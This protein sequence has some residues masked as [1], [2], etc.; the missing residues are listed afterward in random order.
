MDEKKEVEEVEYTGVSVDELSAIT[1]SL[2]GAD[3]DKVEVVEQEEDNLTQKFDIK[4]RVTRVEQKV[5]IIN[6]PPEVF[7]ITKNA[8]SIDDAELVA[9]TM[10][11][12]L[13]EVL[14]YRKQIGDAYHFNWSLVI[15]SD[16]QHPFEPNH[17]NMA[18]TEISYQLDTATLAANLRR[19]FSGIVAGNVKS[20]GIK[21]IR[22]QG[23]FKI[24]GDIK[25]MKLMDTLLNSFVEQQRM[26]L[27]GS[28]YTPC[29]TVV[30]GS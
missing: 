25:I 27:P 12:G 7:L 28:T 10:S 3:V 4:F 17:E 8:T 11:K 14:S 16:F 19:I 22:N 1:E 9:Q 15:E 13:E 30:T 6:V 2:K 5:C 23:V 18:N 29:Y 24:S 21:A 20:E 26:K